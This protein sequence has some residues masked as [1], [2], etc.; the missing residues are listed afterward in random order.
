MEMFVELVFH[1]IARPGRE[2]RGQCPCCGMTDHL[3]GRIQNDFPRQVSGGERC[4]AVKGATRQFITPGPLLYFL[5]EGCQSFHSLQYGVASLPHCA[6]CCDK[7]LPCAFSPG[8]TK[9]EILPQLAFLTHTLQVQG[10]AQ[11]NS[12]NGDGAF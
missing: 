12:V 9:T 4:F 5:A 10:L 3:R 8:F 11:I 1:F 7:H 2:A 6:V